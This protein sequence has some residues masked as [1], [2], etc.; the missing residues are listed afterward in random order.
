ME[1]VLYGHAKGGH[2]PTLWCT[3]E[4]LLT[5]T[6]YIEMSSQEIFGVLEGKR[7]RR[8]HWNHWGAGMDQQGISKGASCAARFRLV[9]GFSLV[10]GMG[11]LQCRV[12]TLLNGTCEP[13]PFV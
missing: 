7:E 11:A 12:H 8:W 5:M 3:V 9:S 10:L 2:M 4:P 1:A 13:R 6:S